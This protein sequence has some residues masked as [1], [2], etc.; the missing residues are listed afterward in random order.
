MTGLTSAIFGGVVYSCIVLIVSHSLLGIAFGLQDCTQ[1]SIFAL[2]SLASGYLIQASFKEYMD[3]NL[4][5]SSVVILFIV[6]IWI[7]DLKHG[8]K[9]N[10]NKEKYNLLKQESEPFYLQHH[11]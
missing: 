8:N 7:Y 10:A 6:I 5:V 11:L 9:F 2:D 4:I 1:Q 3:F